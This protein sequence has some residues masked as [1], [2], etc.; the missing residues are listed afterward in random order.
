MKK[1]SCFILI[2]ALLLLTLVSCSGYNIIM[3]DHLSDPENYQTYEAILTDIYYQDPVTKEVIGDLENSKIT[4]YETVFIVTFETTEDVR[5]FWGGTPNPD[6]S[7]EE[8]NFALHVNSDNS[9]ILHSNGFY[10]SVSLGDKITVTASSW[11]YMD[12]DFFYIT[13]LE[14]DGTEYLTFDEGL[15]NIVDMMNKNKSIF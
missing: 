2:L 13:Q 15:K 14:C 1:F 10:D 4:D 8:F 12:G 3:R 7:P 6:I 11:I 5:A 9:K